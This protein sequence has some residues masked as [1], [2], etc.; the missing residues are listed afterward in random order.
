MCIGSCS[1]G[2]RKLRTERNISVP[3]HDREVHFA[4]L[5]L[6]AIFRTLIY[7]HFNPYG[8]DSDFLTLTWQICQRISGQDTRSASYSL[9]CYKLQPKL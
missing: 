1:I 7:K 8:I 4:P 5:E 3:S 9:T 2:C 6:S